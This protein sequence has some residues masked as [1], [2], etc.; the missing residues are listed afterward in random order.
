MI[1]RLFVTGCAIVTLS[2]GAAFAMK[3]PKS[4]QVEMCQN[5]GEANQKMVLVSEKH[6]NSRKAKGDIEGP[7]P[8]PGPSNVVMCHHPGARSQKTVTV[9]QKKVNSRKAKGDIEG[10]CPSSPRT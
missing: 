2:T 8:P 3:E 4:P 6:L 5:P 7:C 9:S 10:P 1:K